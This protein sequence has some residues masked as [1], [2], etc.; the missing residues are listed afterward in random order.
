MTPV[1]ALLFGELDYNLIDAVRVFVLCYEGIAQIE[2]ALNY[3]A[4]LCVSEGDSVFPLSHTNTTSALTVSSARSRMLFILR[5]HSTGSSAL[6][7]S[8]T[9]SEEA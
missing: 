4:A 5:T 2:Q 7:C 8:V 6:S 1:P 3:K 9:P